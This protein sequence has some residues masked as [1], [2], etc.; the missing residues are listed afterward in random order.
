MLNRSPVAPTSNSTLVLETIIPLSVK[1]SKDAHNGI[2]T[3]ESASSVLAM[4]TRKLPT[5]TR[6]LLEATSCG[7][8]GARQN[9]LTT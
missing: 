8:S 4:R 6:K 3:N 2:V 5:A 9:L 7:P 1:L